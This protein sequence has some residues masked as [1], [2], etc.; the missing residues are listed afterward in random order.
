MLILGYDEAFIPGLEIPLPQLSPKIAGAA[1]KDDSLPEQ[2]YLDYLHYTVVMNKE[3]RQLIYAASNIDQNKDESIPRDDSKAWETDSRI[4]EGYQLDN[5]FYKSNDWDRGHMVQRDNNNW[6]ENKAEAIKANDDT[7]Y[8]T[9][10]AFQHKYF[11][12]DEWLKLEK[13]IG[14]WKDDTNGRLC[15]FTGPVHLPFDRQ[16]ARNWHDTVR[17]PSAFFKIVCYHSKSSNKLES[18]AFV[19]YQ[20]NEFIGNKKSGAG[21]IKLKNYQVTIAEIEELTGLDFDPE[22][23]KNN[24]LYYSEGANDSVNNYPERIPVE[25][26]DDI[27]VD[28]D[29]P[30]KTQEAPDNSKVVAIAAAMI[31]PTGRDLASD[32]WVSLLNI[33][34]KEQVLAGWQLCDDRNRSV[35]LSGE[36]IA[37][38]AAIAIT[39]DRGDMRLT[40]KGGTIILKN[41]KGEVVDRE[42]FSDKDAKVENIGVR[43]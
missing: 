5:R 14:D 40:N 24:P 26:E 19:L 12:Q 30:R 18:R 28:I 23:S 1:F 34:S 35:D 36:I 3:T 16:Y 29:A 17:I 31:N 9:N 27:V 21:M 32:E 33:S 4:P 42:Y 37:P 22:I 13:F 7:F 38:G 43:F 25:H 20:D 10:A 2:I 6:G 8:Y 39:M 41:D 11:N 15:V